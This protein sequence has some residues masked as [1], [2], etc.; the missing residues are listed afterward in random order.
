MLTGVARAWI[1][2]LGAV[3]VA[4]G[5]ARSAPRAAAGPVV[6]KHGDDRCGPNLPESCEA[7]C[8]AGN[9]RACAIYGLA[10][11]GVA[12]APVRLHPNRL[13][14]RRA[15][16]H[17]CHKLDNLDACEFLY[18]Y[19]YDYVADAQFAACD[20]WLR[21]CARGHVRSCG[22]GAACL[23]YEQGY[24][25]DVER[26]LALFRAGCAT[27]D[28]VNCR[29]L[30]FV[31]E[32]GTYVDADLPTAFAN[33]KRACERDDPLAC[34]HLGRFYE[35]GIGTKADVEAARPL[36]R[37]SCARGIKRLPCEA[38]GRLGEEPPPITER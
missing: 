21:L 33:M 27:G 19:E 35:R 29:N 18:G 36:Y 2:S 11:E 31:Q 13:R 7:A 15:L 10:V 14:G 16:E 32:K 30:A 23:L 22:H 38:L 9:G 20:G 34:A 3:L 1:M 17:G 8:F 4:V 25:H 28:A 12:D 6:A 24:P 37:A 26:A 5:C